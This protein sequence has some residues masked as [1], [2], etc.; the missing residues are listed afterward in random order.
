MDTILIEVKNRRDA[1][2]LLKFSKE[3]GWK[4]QSR[5]QLLK[6]LIDT[7][8][9]NVPLTDTDIMEEIRSVRADRKNG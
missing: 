9:E 3:N 5:N 8:P 6:K 2:L 4:V 7:A 1:A